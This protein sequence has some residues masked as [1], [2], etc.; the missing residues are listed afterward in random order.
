MSHED[1]ARKKQIGLSL[2]TE[3]SGS[4]YLLLINSRKDLNIFNN[5]GLLTGFI[6]HLKH[7]RCV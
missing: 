4:Y 1:R 2:N 5:V 7:I 3:L 6:N